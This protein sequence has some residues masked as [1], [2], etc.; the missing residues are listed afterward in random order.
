VNNLKYTDDNG[1]LYL[2]GKIKTLVGTKVDKVEGKGLSTNDF[3]TEEKTKLATLQ[4]YDDTSISNRVT[5]L[6]N[7]GYQTQSQVQ[8]LINSSLSSVMTYKGTVANYSDLPSQDVAVGD[9]YNITNASANNNA[10]DNATWNGTTWD[11]LGSNIDLSSY[12]QRSE[13]VAITN[14]EI[15]TM[16]SSV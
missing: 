16:W 4:N 9:T 1:L 12:L 7:A 8:T 2:I 15:D 10:G 5:T 3:T 11:I 6:E 14:N 13:L